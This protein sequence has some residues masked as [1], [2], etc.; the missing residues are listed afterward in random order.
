MPQTCRKKRAVVTGSVA[1]LKLRFRHSLPFE[2]V[3]VE[4][5]QVSLGEA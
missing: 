1:G 4:G 5:L 3:V 2:L